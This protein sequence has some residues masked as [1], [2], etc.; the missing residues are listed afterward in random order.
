MKIFHITKYVRPLYT[1]ILFS[2][3]FTDFSEVTWLLSMLRVYWLHISEFRFTIIARTLS[4]FI[5]M[6]F[7][8][9]SVAIW[10]SLSGAIVFQ[11]KT[12][13]K[14]ILSSAK[15]CSS[16]SSNLQ[17]ILFVK[18]WKTIEPSID[19]WGTPDRS[20]WKTICVLFILTLC[21]RLFRY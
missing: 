13:D 8:N 12:A 14:I 20:T 11:Q 21:L 16:D 5:I 6:L 7:L 10:L 3:F 4:A 1:L 19:N 17:N 15:L 18:I 9:Q 2:G